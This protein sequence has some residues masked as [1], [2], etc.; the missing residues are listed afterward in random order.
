[1]E[2]NN[3]LNRKI[4]VLEHPDRLGTNKKGIDSNSSSRC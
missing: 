4:E 3:I 1:M 2:D